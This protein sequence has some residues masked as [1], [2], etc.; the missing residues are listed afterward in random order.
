MM[1][2]SADGADEDPYR[3]GGLNP[4]NM[5][6]RLQQYRTTE[7]DPADA[8]DVQNPHTWEDPD[9]SIRERL[10]PGTVAG[11]MAAAVGFLAV[12][13]LTFYLF[14]LVGAA[15][16]NEAVLAGVAIVGFLV[17]FHLWSRQQGVNAVV[18]LDKSIINYGDEA[19]IRLGTY[20]GTTGRSYLFTPYV[21]LSY[22]GFNA[23]P[24][25]KRDLPFS[26]ARL[27]SNVGRKDAVGEEPVVDRLNQ[28]TVKE[29]T[30]TFGKTFVTH[31]ESM[32]FDSFGRESDRFTTSPT[33]ID[34]D[35]ARQM[36]EMIESLETSIRTLE[37]QRR[38][39][40]ERIDDIRDTKQ[41]AIVDELRG[42]INLMETMTDLAAKQ[43][44]PQSRPNAGRN[45]S[46]SNG[47]DPVSKIEQEIRDEQEDR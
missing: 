24:L 36:N 43:Q 38:M 3:G 28:T 21:D 44:H 2:E 35:V 32:Q 47:T 22:G 6:H 4:F 30:D 34:E 46:M 11:W 41:T 17:F 18:Q 40:E 15:F 8:R 13:G 26:A 25:K 9:P 45:G 42:A 19:D 12:G 7:T 14:P 16:R 5:P 20:Q 33:T 1:S 29:D 31:A 23:R 27:R 10:T 37:Q 39:L